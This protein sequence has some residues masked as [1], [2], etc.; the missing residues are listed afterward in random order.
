MK[1]IK[2]LFIV[3]IL[4]IVVL[5]SS[6]AKALEN[7]EVYYTNNHD[8]SF[9][10]E[11]YDFVSMFYF[12]GYQKL[13]TQEDYNYMIDNKLMDGEIQIAEITDNDG[14]NILEDTSHTTNS[15]RLKLTSSCDGSCYMTLTLTWLISPA[16]R[17]YD[18]VGAYSTTSNNL[19]FVGAR[20]YYD[21]V[22]TQYTENRK[23]SN[24]VSATFKLPTSG[25]DIIVVMN[26]TA[27]KGTTVQ[28]AY[29]HAKKSITLA[30]SRKYTFAASGYGGVYRFDTSV[31]DYFDAMAGVKLTL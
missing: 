30:N 8:V 18:L 29:Q 2:R 6:N 14:I 9:T 25:E 22:V 19:S 3:I 7:D 17:S 23:E 28:A 10:K 4:L 27:S 20:M 13:M 24:G 12:D 26:F 31:V 5:F 15:K 1:V 16:V 21:E 11:E